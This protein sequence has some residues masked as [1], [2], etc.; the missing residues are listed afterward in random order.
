[1]TQIDL[2][3]FYDLHIHSSP[4]VTPRSIDDIE[5][6]TQAANAGMSGILLKSHSTTTADRAT[7]AGK[8][9]SGVVVYGSLT[10]NE[11]VGG[12]NI[13]AVETA[14][15]LGA[16][17]IF[18]PTISAANNLQAQNR[19]GGISLISNN[20]LSVVKEIVALIKEKNAIL[21][22]GHI[23]KEEIELLVRIATE[24]GLKKIVVT[25]P[26]HPL[27]K[28]TI[29][30]Q[31]DFLERGVYF[32][33]CFAST[34]PNIGD[35]PIEQIATA[36]KEIGAS[37]TLLTTDLGIVNYPVPVDGMRIYVDEL[38]ALGIVKEDIAVMVKKIPQMLVEK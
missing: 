4:D 19:K 26:E 31:R 8:I 35:V 3:G 2:T 38:Q 14:L 10:L 12:L 7:I 18:M 9:V 29:P 6:A 34:L 17:E 20:Q 13:A 36:I 32:E 15:D 25:H 37:S 11:S 1:M 24:Q 33:R 27:I 22:T 30:E 21:G 5:A 23:S 28:L 16:R